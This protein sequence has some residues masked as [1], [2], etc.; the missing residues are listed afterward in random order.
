LTAAAMAAAG[1]HKP[2]NT[3]IA[4]AEREKCFFIVHTPMTE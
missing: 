1:I 2:I 4:K 3:A